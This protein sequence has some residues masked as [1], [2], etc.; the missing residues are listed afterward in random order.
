VGVLIP[1]VI[2]TT[3]NKP[4]QD[5]PSTHAVFQAMPEK[6]HKDINSRGPLEGIGMHTD[7][8]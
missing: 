6:E 2:I 7:T 5:L 1:L 4:I 3:Y 8:S